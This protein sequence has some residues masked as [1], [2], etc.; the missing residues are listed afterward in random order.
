M[1]YDGGGSYTAPAIHRYA[2]KARG[3]R[4]LGGTD[5]LCS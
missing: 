5:V 3:I 2:D 1:K 4:R